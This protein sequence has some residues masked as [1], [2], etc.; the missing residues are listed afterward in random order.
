[1]SNEPMLHV[2]TLLLT[3]WLIHVLVDY[4][5]NVPPMNVSTIY[6]LPQPNRQNEVWSLLKDIAPPIDNEWLL[7]GDF[8]AI[9]HAHEKIGGKSFSYSKSKPFHECMHECNLFDLGFTGPIY[10]WTNKH[11]NQ[12]THI[13]ERLD[14]CLGN[15]KW[16]SSFPN[17][18]V[19]H[20]VNS[21]SDHSPLFLYTDPIN[22]PFCK[23]FIFDAAWIFDTSY[24]TVLN[25]SWST[26][27]NIGGTMYGQF[28]VFGKLF[29]KK[30]R[31]W[32]KYTYGN[33]G[34]NIGDIKKNCIS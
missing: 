29:E 7:G 1:M 33:W 25:H 23:R 27:C 10:T 6:N 21:S 28:H 19:K 26:A 15:Q 32:K 3:P 30:T 20:L 8:N 14:R 34:N 11:K 12:T 4:Y 2:T 31:I 5:P 24:I 16:I 22:K 17:Y 18:V 9:L 13:R